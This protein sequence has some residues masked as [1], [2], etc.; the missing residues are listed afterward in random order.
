MSHT[1]TCTHTDNWNDV[2][3]AAEATLEAD[4]V[5]YISQCAQSDRPQ[6]HLISIL[7]RVQGRYSYLSREHM[8]AVAQ[9]LGVPTSSVT[10][11]ATFYHFFRLQP[12]GRYKVSVCLGTACYV[13]GAQAIA[14]RLRAE[15]GVEFGQTSADNMFTL[16]PARCL[17]TCGL[18]PV[19][20]IDGNVHGPITAD[21]VPA[22]LEKYR[23]AATHAAASA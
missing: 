16:E 4:I 23:L 10:G 19:I 7:H 15:L 9:L 3:A 22:T 14:D 18:A 1:C 5:T 6:S 20:M 2:R 21:Q 17:G 12:Q 13:K 8:D 11:V